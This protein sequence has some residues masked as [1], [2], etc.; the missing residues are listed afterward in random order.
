MVIRV[1]TRSRKDKKYHPYKTKGSNNL[2]D[3]RV[4]EIVQG[5]GKKKVNVH[6]K[7][8]NGKSWLRLGTITG[9]QVR[10]MMLGKVDKSNG[11]AYIS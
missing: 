1:K 7:G 11:K 6:Y 4:G 2:I 9:V 8:I 10:N 5:N 3:I